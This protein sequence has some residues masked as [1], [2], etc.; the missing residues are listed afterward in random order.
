MERYEWG[1]VT[2]NLPLSSY[3]VTYLENCQERS[4]NSVGA[5]FLGIPNFTTLYILYSLKISNCKL[6]MK[7]F[8]INSVEKYQSALCLW[9]PEIYV[10]KSFEGIYSCLVFLFTLSLPIH[11][12]T[13]QISLTYVSPLPHFPNFDPYCS[14]FTRRLCYVISRSA[15]KY[16]LTEHFK[17]LMLYLFHYS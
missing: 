3:L 5:E 14:K 12:I 2:P 17:Y 1:N 9:S 13:K 15:C 7:G 6:Y 11:S 8:V 4:H 16:F 10:M